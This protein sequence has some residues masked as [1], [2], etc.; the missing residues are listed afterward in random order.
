M[1]TTVSPYSIRDDK[2][3]NGLYEFSSLF[4]IERICMRYRQIIGRTKASHTDV[5]NR[6]EIRKL[7][8]P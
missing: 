3:S 5:A 8:R 7:F 6:D 1:L 2:K 4:L